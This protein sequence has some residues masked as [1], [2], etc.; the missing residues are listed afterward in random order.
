MNKA[1]AT[2]IY[3]GSERLDCGH[4]EKNSLGRE[5]SLFKD[6]SQKNAWCDHG[7][8]RRGQ[9]TDRE[10]TDKITEACWVRSFSHGQQLIR[11]LIKCERRNCGM[12]LKAESG[13][14]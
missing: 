14:I 8:T 6:L 13:M 3:K 9:G 5:N 11:T 7:T 1:A 4:L 10:Y 12:I 2:P